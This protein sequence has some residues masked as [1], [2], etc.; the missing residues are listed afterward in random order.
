MGRHP[1]DLFIKPCFVTLP[2]VL[3]T[4]LISGCYRQWV[5]LGDMPNDAG[6]QSEQR[7]AH[8]RFEGNGIK[9]DV[10]S[11]N[12]SGR[13]DPA[14]PEFA[15]SLRLSFKEIGY[16]FDPRQVRLVL[17]G[18]GELLPQRIE[19]AANAIGWESSWECGPGLRQWY[20]SRKQGLAFSYVAE[21]RIERPERMLPLSNEACF[22]FYFP[23]SPPCPDTPF[24]LRIRG[25]SQGN[26]SVEIPE[27][28]F[29]KGS[30][31]VWDFLGR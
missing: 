16:Q 7:V 17:P 21:G 6:W 14:K 18:M 20:F 12:T 5:S 4:F 29:K 31:W 19:M 23:I 8:N 30:F 28:K 1:L 3:A 27:V 11:S 9:L 26:Q 25:L 22:E 13:W 15:L 10:A 2:I 24:I